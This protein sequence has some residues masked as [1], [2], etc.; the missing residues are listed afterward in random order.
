MRKLRLE[1]DALVVETFDT[2]ARLRGAGTIRGAES[3]APD[4]R[5]ELCSGEPIETC[6]CQCRTPDCTWQSERPCTPI[7]SEDDTCCMATYGPCTCEP[8]ETCSCA[9][10]AIG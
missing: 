10:P 6:T 5:F 1:L 9:V 8:I 7:E 2:A 4:T 3:V